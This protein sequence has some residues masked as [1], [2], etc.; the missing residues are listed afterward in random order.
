ML[1]KSC[2]ERVGHISEGFGSFIFYP[3]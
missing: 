1:S 3:S 2:T